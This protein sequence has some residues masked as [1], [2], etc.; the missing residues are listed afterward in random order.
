MMYRRNFLASMALA[1]LLSSVVSAE[2]LEDVEQFVEEKWSGITSFRADISI[3]IKV[4]IGPIEIPSNANGTIEL[5][6]VEEG[7][8]FRVEVKNHLAKN[9]LMKDGLTQDVLT[10]FDGEYEYTETT[11][12]GRKQ[13][14]KHVPKTAGANQPMG[15]GAVFERMR[16]QGDVSFG[17]E[18]KIDGMAVWII[19]V[20]ANGKPMEV[21]API[22]PSRIRVYLSQESGVQVRMVMYDEDN[23]E[24][25]RMRYSNLQL[26]PELDLTRFTYTPPPGVE[27]KIGKPLT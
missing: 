20:K 12:F 9:F 5:M 13:V 3:D 11:V 15:G 14:N 1:A 18:T 21:Q 27:V 26:N 16:S 7:R 25:L 8:K 4:P 17:G 23:E 6:M 19:D 10:V 24:V 2:T 22:E